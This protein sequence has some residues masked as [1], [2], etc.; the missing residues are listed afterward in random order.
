M[1]LEVFGDEV[2]WNY[3]MTGKEG[4]AVMVQMRKIEAEIQN[5]AKTLQKE[6]EK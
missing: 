5:L 2:D 3:I 6:E 1:L 4:G